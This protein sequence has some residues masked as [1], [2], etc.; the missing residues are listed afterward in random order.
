LHAEQNVIIQAAL[1]GI[2]IKD[3]TL[4]STC[5]PCGLC[6]KMLINTGIKRIAYLDYHPDPLADA[7]AQ[8]AQLEIVHIDN[9]SIS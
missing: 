7:I 5:F 6:M 4:Y 3:A 8:E 2:T 1:H 9:N